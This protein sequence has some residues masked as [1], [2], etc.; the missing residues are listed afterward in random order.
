M[1]G[2]ERRPQRVIGS[3]AH[4]SSASQQFTSIPPNLIE[5]R[6]LKDFLALTD[7]SIVFGLLFT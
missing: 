7:I 4:S 3:S 6:V 5:S 2:A 1:A